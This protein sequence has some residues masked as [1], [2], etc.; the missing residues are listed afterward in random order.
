MD[1]KG[2]VLG[3]ICVEIANVLRGKHLRTFTKGAD[4]GDRV[5]VLNAQEV[6]LTGKKYKNKKYYRHTGYPG[7][8]KTRTAEDIM[9]SDPSEIIKKAVK[10]MLSRGPLG[11]TQLG[12]LKVFSQGEHD[13]GSLRPE[14]WAP[15]SGYMNPE[16]EVKAEKVVS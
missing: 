16:S 8:L 4:C 2:K 10:G 7:G 5:I 12:N 13:L 1:A 9:T 6:V 3:R 14:V 15:K 11:R